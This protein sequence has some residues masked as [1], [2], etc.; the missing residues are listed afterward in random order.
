MKKI[1]VICCIICTEI[2]L[3]LLLAALD[4][5]YWLDTTAAVI[6]F[7]GA[8]TLAGLELETKN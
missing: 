3:F 7:F 4:L 8:Y 5:P 2:N 1:L 6:I